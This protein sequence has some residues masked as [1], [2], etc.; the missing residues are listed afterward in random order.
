[1]VKRKKKKK[2]PLTLFLD[3]EELSESRNLFSLRTG[4]ATGKALVFTT[5]VDKLWVTLNVAGI[6]ITFFTD[7]G[8][9]ISSLMIFS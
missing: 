2:M 6:K 3:C 1:M 8:E 7:M 4:E 5:S 9:I